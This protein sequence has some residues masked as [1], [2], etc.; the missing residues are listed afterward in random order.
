M[1]CSSVLCKDN[2]SCYFHRETVALEC[3]VTKS[4]EDL[5]LKDFQLSK[6]VLDLR[7][8]LSGNIAKDNPCN[9]KFKNFLM[10]EK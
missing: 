2:Y 5:F 1:T 10:T 3:Y 6:I 8:R 4:K 9:S 7:V